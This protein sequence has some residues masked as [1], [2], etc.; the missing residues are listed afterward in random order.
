MSLQ[1]VLSGST[2]NA[3]RRNMSFKVTRPTTRD[4]TPGTIE[5]NPPVVH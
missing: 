1:D 5:T 4:P 2:Q 3:N